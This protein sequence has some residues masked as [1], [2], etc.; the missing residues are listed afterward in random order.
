MLYVQAQQTSQEMVEEPPNRC[1][2]ITFQKACGKVQ[3]RVFFFND[4]GLLAFSSGE[5]MMFGDVWGVDCF[6][7]A[8]SFK[9]V[10]RVRS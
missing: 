5:L 7:L 4:L 10:Y 1:V 6:L 2:G 8:S 9:G 3:R